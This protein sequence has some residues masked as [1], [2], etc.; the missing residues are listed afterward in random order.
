MR[1]LTQNTFGIASLVA[2][3]R[4]KH[5][6]A[7]F[8]AVLCRPRVRLGRLRWRHKW[9]I[10]VFIF[11]YLYGV[12]DM[13]EPDCPSVLVV[14]RRAKRPS[15]SRRGRRGRN[16]CRRKVSDRNLQMLEGMAVRSPLPD[17]RTC[18]AFAEHGGGS[19]HYCCYCC[20]V[21]TER[22]C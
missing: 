13:A 15:L 17:R 22:C 7:T 21:S 20:N 19:C 11:V 4:R 14:S 1:R 9:I 12:L 18:F 5:G 3:D 8:D 10:L 6:A 2:F 16:F